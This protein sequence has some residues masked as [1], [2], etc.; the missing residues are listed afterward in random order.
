MMNAK[1]EHA[2]K[3]WENGKKAHKIPFAEDLAKTRFDFQ[4]YLIY[5][6]YLIFISA[7]HTIW[8]IGKG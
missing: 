3:E 2:L 7:M 1:I 5:N 6:I 4:L 8:V